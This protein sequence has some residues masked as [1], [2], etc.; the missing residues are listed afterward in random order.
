MLFKKGRF[1]DALAALSRAVDLAPDDHE[2]LVLPGH[3]PLI[4]LGEKARAIADI[5]RATELAPKRPEYVF[6]LLSVRH[7]G[8]PQ[9]QIAALE[10]PIARFPE[11]TIFLEERAQLL[12]KAGAPDRALLDWDCLVARWPGDADY[13][14][15]RAKALA[16]A[17]RFEDALEEVNG[18]IE[19]DPGHALA[20]RA[21]SAPT[22]HATPR[23]DGDRCAH[24]R[25][26]GP[27]RGARPSTTWRPATT[28]VTTSVSNEAY[29]AALE[30]FD[31]V[32]ALSPSFAEARAYFHR[33]CARFMSESYAVDGEADDLDEQDELVEQDERGDDAEQD[34][35]GEIDGD[36]HVAEELDEMYEA[37]EDARHRACVAD[38]ERAIELG[39]REEDVFGE[40]HW[41]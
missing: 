20:H 33:G 29:A 25:R 36:E 9:A 32:V 6:F 11:A 5:E 18:A 12:V 3:R 15:G 37:A 2:A 23:I 26:L 17:D 38:F 16:A 7:E 39:Y 4:R 30:D 8:D 31:R 34:A 41:S 13:R 28:G 27:R 21:E 1:D 35:E 22:T 19:K 10:D 24:R 40:L 14:V